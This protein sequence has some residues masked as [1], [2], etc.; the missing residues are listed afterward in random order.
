M[1]T[2]FNVHVDV[3]RGLLRDVKIDSFGGLLIPNGG[4]TIR[5][6]ETG[7]GMSF[8]DSRDASYCRVRVVFLPQRAKRS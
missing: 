4:D 6:A 3:V 2:R 1:S 5:A 8:E 7:H